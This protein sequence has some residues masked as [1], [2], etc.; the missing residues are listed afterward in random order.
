MPCQPKNTIFLEP[1]DIDNYDAEAA[2][3]KI[4]YNT[5]RLKQY[6]S[7]NPPWIPVESLPPPVQYTPFCVPDYKCG[8]GVNAQ[9]WCWPVDDTYYQPCATGSFPIYGV[10]GMH[11]H[12]CYSQSNDTGS[13]LC[14]LRGHKEVY[15]SG[16]WLGR[17]GYT[18][19]ML[20]KDD[21]MGWCCSCAGAGHGG[22]H[23]PDFTPDQT[24]YRTIS[25]DTTLEY[26]SDNYDFWTSPTPTECCCINDGTG[27]C[28]PDCGCAEGDDSCEC[29][30]GNCWTKT[31][32]GTD[33]Y[34][35][36][37]T[38][39]CTI[40]KYGNLHGSCTSGSSGWCA[41][42]EG[43]PDYMYSCLA[44][45]AADGFAGVGAAESNYTSLIGMWCEGIRQWVGCEGCHYPDVL[46]WD[47]STGTG[48]AEWHTTIHDT[49]GCGC[50]IASHDVIVF[51]MTLTQTSFDSTTYGINNIV[52]SGCPC[53]GY[54]PEWIVIATSHTDYGMTSMHAHNYGF[55]PSWSSAF[56][57]TRD[58]EGSM[59][60]PY[61]PNEVYNDVVNNL[62]STWD[63]GSTIQYPWQNDGA[64]THGPWVCRD[65]TGG[66]P[67]I[68]YCS[69]SNTY[70]G[71][72]C[73]A[74]A[75]E[76]IDRVWNPS[77]PV[78][79]VCDDPND[80][81]NY[82]QYTDHYGQWSTEGCGVPRATQWLDTFQA[83]NFMDGAMVGSNFMYSMPCRN[84]SNGPSKISDD[85]IWACKTAEILIPTIQ[86]F[87]YARPCGSDRWQISS[88]GTNCIREFSESKVTIDVGEYGGGPNYIKTGLVS[89]CN[90]FIY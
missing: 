49:N 18:S 36:Y 20:M 24:K 58:T 83:N 84:N 34:T 22:F 19:R 90:S 70:T 62:L 86:E 64:K 68:G 81:G 23:K 8:D 43:N 35:A 38:S 28:C 69:S 87:A 55:N 17:Y 66:A 71:R 1:G 72:I 61:S 51:E 53:D 50:I 5:T 41:W 85:V 54:S 9:P 44:N 21:S 26:N 73:G 79:C 31:Y 45:A 46:D 52:T 76:G 37:G 10:G 77:A 42:A 4:K 12:N 29:T 82:C 67:S 57:G 27:D 65:A 14:L 15:G 80:P 32:T 89:I 78:I 3:V 33:T 75:V 47:D 6:S 63:L 11:W 39:T 25:A 59:A 16:I 48:H 88:S 56:R 2:A 60:D 40:D 13:A 30:W 7:S 74:P